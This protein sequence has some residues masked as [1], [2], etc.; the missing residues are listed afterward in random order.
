M[1]GGG[2]LGQVA[3]VGVVCL[4]VV[5]VVRARTEGAVSFPLPPSITSWEP[6]LI[7]TVSVPCP[8]STLLEEPLRRDGVIAV[9][10]DDLAVRSVADRHGVVAVACL[11]AVRP[12]AETHL[13]VAVP[14]D[15]GVPAVPGDDESLPLPSKMTWFP[16][17]ASMQS[18]PPKPLIQKLDPK[19]KMRSLPFVP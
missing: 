14:D 16:S 5:G 17:P 10:D 3:D 8:S 19:A 2:R 7:V 4:T 1:P 18:L 11:H 13:V 6:A 9:A 15:D 12:V